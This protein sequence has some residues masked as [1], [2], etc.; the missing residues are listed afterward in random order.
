MPAW[1]KS[2][3]LAVIGIIKV[4]LMIVVNFNGIFVELGHFYEILPVSRP[5]IFLGCKYFYRATFEF[6]GLEIGHLAAVILINFPRDSDC[7][8]HCT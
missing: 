3:K 2:L 5:L 1:H 7:M 6:C 4:I 8:P